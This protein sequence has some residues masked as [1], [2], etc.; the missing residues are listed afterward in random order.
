MQP[1]ASCRATRRDGL[2][3]TS[4]IVLASGYCGAH[5]P[6][7]RQQMAEAR[8]RGGQGRSS[9]ARLRGL[10]PPRLVPVFGRLETALDDVL[11][12]KL[13]PRQATAAASV[14]RALVAVLTAGELEERVRQLEAQ[15]AAES[16]WGGR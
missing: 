14:A 13:D 12:G 9:A 3:C 16:E 8:T 1:V 2:P 5:D 6:E 7:R 10:L 11:S 15:S 4:T